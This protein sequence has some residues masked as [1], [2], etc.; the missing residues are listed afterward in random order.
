MVRTSG[1]V[2]LPREDLRPGKSVI[3]RGQQPHTPRMTRWECGRNPRRV[4]PPQ[5]SMVCVDCTPQGE[6]EVCL[7][8]RSDCVT[9]RSFDEA[10]RMASV[11][12]GRREPCDVIVRD[13][14]H[15][16]IRRQLV[17]ADSGRGRPSPRA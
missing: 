10:C 6:W 16:V 5:P 1:I 13:A 15:R 7:A 17:G 9:C 14:Y 11:M 2:N 8:G 3:H 4:R 12:A